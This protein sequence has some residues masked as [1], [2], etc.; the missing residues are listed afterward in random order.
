MESID[1]FTSIASLIGE[2]ARARILWSLLD[3]RA[4]TAGEL[5]L[6]ANLSP[7]SASNHLSRMIDAGLLKVEKQGKH[8]YYRYAKDKVAYAVEALSN[9]MPS[10]MKEGPAPVLNNGDI[11]FARTCYD[12][13]AGKVAVKITHGLLVQKIIRPEEDEYRLTTRGVQWFEDLGIGIAGLQQQ[14]RHFAKPCLDWT[15]RKHHLA[16]ALGA[17]LLDHM[18]NQNWLRRKPQ[19]RTVIMTGKGEKALAGLGISLI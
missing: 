18:L 12:H 1:R 15:E 13:L 7:Q 8:R 2:P 3:G 14:K 6:T 16:G 4:Y 19:E 9:L 17:A 5:A 10:P 11:R